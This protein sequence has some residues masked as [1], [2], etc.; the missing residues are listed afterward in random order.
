MAE[1][2]DRRSLLAFLLGTRVRRLER[3][4]SFQVRGEKGEKGMAER[5][6]ALLSGRVDLSSQGD[7]WE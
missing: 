3:E 5:M 1:K 2:G 6:G 7:A 4:R